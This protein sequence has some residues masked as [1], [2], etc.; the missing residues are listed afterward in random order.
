MQ[1]RGTWLCGIDLAH[2]GNVVVR[3]STFCATFVVPDGFERVPSTTNTARDGFRS[4]TPTHLVCLHRDTV[5]IDTRSIHCSSCNAWC[6]LLP[7]HAPSSQSPRFLVRPPRHAHP[8]R[9]LSFLLFH[10]GR[11]RYGSSMHLRP[12]DVCPRFTTLH[13]VVARGPSRRAP[14]SRFFSRRGTYRSRLVRSGFDLEAWEDGDRRSERCQG[15]CKGWKRRGGLA[16]SRV[17][18]R[19]GSVGRRTS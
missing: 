15:R 10:R 3:A 9:A 19:R 12:W 7:S 6:L 11:T 17:H 14:S 2:I 5:R 1:C 4:H 13:N 16:A 18:R 8:P